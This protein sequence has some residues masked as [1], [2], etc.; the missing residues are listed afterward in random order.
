MSYGDFRVSHWRL[1]IWKRKE[2]GLCVHS[3]ISNQWEGMEPF[4]N[5]T[6]SI[7]SPFGEKIKLFSER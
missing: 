2:M 4:N 3:D 5:G 7:E 6:E 1:V